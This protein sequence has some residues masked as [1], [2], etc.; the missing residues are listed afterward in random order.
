MFNKDFHL[1]NELYNARI[2][3]MNLGPN[4]ENSPATGY[5]PDKF[6]A[7][8]K[9]CNCENEECSCKY[10]AA[11]CKCSECAECESNQYANQDEIDVKKSDLNK[12]GKLSK[13][14]KTRGGAIDKA[15]GG[16]GKLPLK[17]NEDCEGC[18]TMHG[19]EH[20]NEEHGGYMTKQ[21]LFRIV[22]IAAMLHDLLSD[23]ENIEPWVLD[24]IARAQGDLNSI[25]GYKDYEK[26]REVLNHSLENVEEE[27][28]ND[29]FSAIHSGGGSLLDALR[30]SLKSESREIVEKVLLEAI[31][32]LET[33]K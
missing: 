25:F 12:D 24:K 17:S 14:E 28:E 5:T 30:K 19:N 9:K 26:H 16:S 11:G 31:K 23:E 10:A 6:V 27:T 1:L 32:V 33:K 29:L 2:N 22:K 13:Y 18:E 15:M 20:S 7:I 3:E 21:N 8:P 4:G